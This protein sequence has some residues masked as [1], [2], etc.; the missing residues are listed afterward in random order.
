M[1]K[2][3]RST[4]HR[5]LFPLLKMQ[6]KPQTAE[7]RPLNYQ[8]SSERAEPGGN[9]AA[10]RTSGIRRGQDSASPYS[11]EQGEFSSVACLGLVRKTERRPWEE[12]LPCHGPGPLVAHTVLWSEL[13]G[14]TARVASG[15]GTSV[16]DSDVQEHCFPPSF[17]LL[18]RDSILKL[19]CL[20]E[21]VLGILLVLP[22]EGTALFWRRLSGKESAVKTS[23]TQPH[24]NQ[25]ARVRPGS[26]VWALRLFCWTSLGSGK[27]LVRETSCG[28]LVTSHLPFCVL[29]TLWNSPSEHLPPWPMNNCAII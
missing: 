13:C 29:S 2:L 9:E 18:L 26:A 7:T 14:P 22:R 15:R 23:R 1:K 11:K 8:P 24:G 10:S 17:S 28:L 21:L 4:S 19:G 6:A 20:R 16:W 27:P 25:M 12:T 5:V 3:H